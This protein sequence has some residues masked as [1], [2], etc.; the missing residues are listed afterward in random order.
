MNWQQFFEFILRAEASD[1][2]R[3]SVKRSYVDMAGD[4]NAGI[5]LSQLMYWTM[6]GKNGETRMRSE[7]DGYLWVS[8]SAQEWHDEIRLTSRQVQRATQLLEDKGLII[9]ALYKFKGA[10][11]KHY[12]IDPERFAKTYSKV[13]G[14]EGENPFIQNRKIQ[15]DNTA[16]SITDST[17]ES[18][19]EVGSKG[20]ASKPKN[21]T[22]QSDDHHIGADGAYKPD[23]QAIF[24]TLEATNNNISAIRESVLDDIDTYGIETVRAVI[25]ESLQYGT[26]QYK[27]MQWRYKA[28]EAR[29]SEQYR[30]LIDLFK[31]DESAETEYKI[32]QFISAANQLQK[33]DFTADDVRALHQ[34]VAR[35][36]NENNWTHWGTNAMLS[37]VG[38]F[39]AHQQKRADAIARQ[40]AQA[41]QIDTEPEDTE[42][43]IDP[44]YW[45]SDVPMPG[46]PEWDAYIEAQGETDNE[47]L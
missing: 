38:E 28:H 9:T 8:K 41:E 22:M 36:A 29:T 43:E 17:T 20:A 19:T 18:S 15:T 5:M 24:E 25:D 10:P 21:E 32:K 40:Q 46:T 3:I 14:Y 1:N 4:L 16:K 31:T 39:R 35:I 23:I 34:Y 45:P 42:P 6:P 37:R 12:R 2:D 44:A 33:K 7:H 47:Y 13:L 11:T 26:R 27:R 30:T